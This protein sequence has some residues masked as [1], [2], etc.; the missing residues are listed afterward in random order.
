MSKAKMM[1]LLKARNPD[2]SIF[3][4]VGSAM[5]VASLALWFFSAD[6][7]YW[8]HTVLTRQG[9]HLDG[10]VFQQ[11]VELLPVMMITAGLVV[12]GGYWYALKFA[13]WLALLGMTAAWFL[14]VASISG[15][16]LIGAWVVTCMVAF[17]TSETYMGTIYMNP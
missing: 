9:L 1:A 2:G 7:A 11:G 8:L 3:M 10:A 5:I 14:P 12:A 16:G 6:L 13:G 17:Y 15:V 4:A